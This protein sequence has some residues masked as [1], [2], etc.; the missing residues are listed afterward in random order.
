MYEMTQGHGV[1]SEEEL[2]FTS[3]SQ[4]SPSNNTPSK[5]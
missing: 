2:R 5:Y 4:L 3:G 1:F